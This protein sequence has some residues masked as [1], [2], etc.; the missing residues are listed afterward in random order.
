MVAKR[1]RAAGRGESNTSTL[2]AACGV[3][4]RSRMEPGERG[5]TVAQ[6]REDADGMQRLIDGAVH[7]R[8]IDFEGS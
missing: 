2:A 7:L 1:A 6:E 8:K 5:C 3:G 4:G